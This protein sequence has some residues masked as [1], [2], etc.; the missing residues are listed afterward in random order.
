MGRIVRCACATR[1]LLGGGGGAFIVTVG[2]GP[3]VLS[4]G[5]TLWR[6]SACY[7]GGCPARHPLLDS[8]GCG[9]LVPVVPLSSEMCGSCRPVVLVIYFHA[10]LGGE[11][12]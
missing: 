9:L 5:G 6:G 4:V 7:D 10:V 2:S 3:L 8:L 12:S 11:A 1:V